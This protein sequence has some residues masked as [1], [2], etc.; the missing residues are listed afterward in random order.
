MISSSRLSSASKSVT[1][2]V[3]ARGSDLVF[4]DAGDEVGGLDLKAVTAANVLAMVRSVDTRKALDVSRRLKQHVSQI[5]RFAIP[6]GWAERD[7]AE[8]LRDLPKAKSR[9]RH[10]ARVGVDELPALV[11][12]IDGHD[13]DETP[14]RRA[15][16]S[17]LRMRTPGFCQL[18]RRAPL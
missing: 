14:R 5:Y 17:S 15:P 2:V 18:S 11:R 16:A 7:P 13:G 1:R 9:V 4:L 8:H 3:S 6:Q 12:A 10:M